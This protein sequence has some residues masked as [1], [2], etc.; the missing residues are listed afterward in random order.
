MYTVQDALADLKKE[1]SFID[2]KIIIIVDDLD[3]LGFS[4]LK[5]ILFVVKKSFSIPDISY[6]LCYDT[7]NIVKFESRGIG[8]EKITEFLEKFVNIKIS[9]YLDS[10]K[11]IRFIDKLVA[12]MRVNT[13]HDPVLIDKAAGGL[14]RLLLSENHHRYLSLVGDARKIKRF[15]NTLILLKL[16]EVSYDEADIDQYDL[17]NLLILYINYP[18]VFRKIFHGETGGRNG[19]VSLVGPYHDGYPDKEELAGAVD[20]TDLENS[21]DF[22]EFFDSVTD[23]NAR[24]LI[25][26][27]FSAKIRKE[28]IKE[29]ES[30][31][32]LRNRLACFN[33]Y[34][35]ERR[36]LENYLMLLTDTKM[37]TPRLQHSF[38]RQR[39]DDVKNGV[40]IEK[41]FERPEFSFDKDEHSH[42]YFWRIILNGG[43]ELNHDVASYVIRYLMRSF[44]KHS[45]VEISAIGLGFRDTLPYFLASLLDSSG[46]SSE[47]STVRNNSA[48][49]ISEISE[50]IYGELRHESDG[51]LE[52]LIDSPGNIIGLFDL[53]LFRLVCS[54]DRGGN[55][56]NLTRAIALRENRN[57]PVEGD[58]KKIAKEQMRNLS[59]KVFGIFKERYIDRRINIFREIKE[60]PDRN[61]M[62]CWADYTEYKIKDGSVSEE[63]V[64]LQIENARFRLVRFICY[65]LSNDNINHGVGCGFYDTYG[66]KDNGGI[67]S[68]ISKYFFSVCFDPESS[69]CGNEFFGDYIMSTIE[70][71]FGGIGK[72]NLFRLASEIDVSSLFEYWMKWSRNVRTYFELNKERRIPCGNTSFV[73]GK[74][75]EEVC[76]TLDKLCAFYGLSDFMSLYK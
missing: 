50:W 24:F 48:E 41:I 4:H 51:V 75:T 6:V 15:I 43:H 36:N 64:R 19:F 39:F 49:N 69:S 10:Q 47:G 59:Q 32:W 1:I 58:V 16:D 17:A 72:F 74:K 46:W 68:E 37:P 12:E 25:G 63:H 56:F 76:H 65:Q 21:N 73:Y 34:S 66:I 2:K 22:H 18:Q 26:Q 42:E 38:Y 52:A 29:S 44:Q 28:S 9:L 7:E 55:L 27:L 8:N 60:L 67:K 62:G 71:D 33:G 14:K 5:E 13:V 11:L 20:N 35:S 30:D 45:L 61:F 31:S 70:S 53:L 57:A 54:A 3:R 40:M 23:I